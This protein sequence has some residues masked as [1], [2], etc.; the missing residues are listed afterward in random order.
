[1]ICYVRNYLITT[2]KYH[3][4]IKILLV[5]D[6]ELIIIIIAFGVNFL[7]GSDLII[8]N[9]LECFSNYLLI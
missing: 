2:H 9:E 8:R 3:D 5:N 4:S 1:M 7:Q 6:I